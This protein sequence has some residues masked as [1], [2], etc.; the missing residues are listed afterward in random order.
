MHGSSLSSGWKV[1]TLSCWAA[2]QAV[3]Y[4]SA[5]MRLCLTHEFMVYLKYFDLSWSSSFCLSLS[6]CSLPCH[7]RA[8]W[9]LL[10]GR[11]A[12]KAPD[13][14]W[15]LHCCCAPNFEITFSIPRA[16]CDTAAASLFLNRLSNHKAIDCCPDAF[17]G[18]RFCHFL[19]LPMTQRSVSF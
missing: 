9:R 14:P 16:H 18:Q 1:C 12:V 5:N 19:M 15:E 11:A 10:A 3:V 8:V 6:A 4:L 7:L 13:F 2:L 17:H